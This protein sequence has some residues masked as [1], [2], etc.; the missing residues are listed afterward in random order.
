M[1][2]DAQIVKRSFRAF[3]VSLMVSR[4]LRITVDPVTGDALHEYGHAG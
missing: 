1:T 3:F 2:S 4:V